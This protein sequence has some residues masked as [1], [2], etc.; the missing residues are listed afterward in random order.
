MKALRPFSLAAMLLD[1]ACG[2]SRAPS[3]VASS[4]GPAS[5]ASANAPLALP[6]MP[7][8]EDDQRAYAT[9]CKDSPSHGASTDPENDDKAPACVWLAK[10]NAEAY[11]DARTFAERAFR[12]EIAAG[13]LETEAIAALERS[14]AQAKR[15]RRAK[16]AARLAREL[17]ATRN[18][19][20]PSLP[21]YDPARSPT[22][23][24]C[25][26]DALGAWG[27][28]YDYQLIPDERATRWELE[29]YVS[30][31]RVTADDGIVASVPLMFHGGP[32]EAK[33]AFN[34]LG[35]AADWSSSS[36]DATLSMPRRFQIMG[37]AALEIALELS[38]GWEAPYW[39]NRSLYAF[40]NGKLVQLASGYDEI[41]DVTGDGIP[42]L[43]DSEEFGHDF[44]TGLGAAASG[45]PFLRHGLPGGTYSNDDEA[46]RAYAARWC[47]YR[48]RVYLS[49]DAV[50]CARLRGADAEEIT[51]WVKNHLKGPCA[52]EGGKARRSADGL[53]PSDDY[54]EMLSKA[55]MSLP[56]VLP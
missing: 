19:A 23:F 22:R 7:W 40:D 25:L 41:E 17:R 9:R 1:L 15:E 53:V 4:H 50:V 34:R 46:A 42:D 52:P 24:T 49:V 32:P 38:G 18:A 21:P 3:V 30:V 26:D 35:H 10:R 54:D 16:D 28:A 55:P 11:A 47:P 8:D 56:F 31:V 39:S 37:D 2:G 48:P 44:C 29:A 43:I 45:P 20:K 33:A 13:R 27:V 12:K 5:V 6:M 14:L 51:T 36:S